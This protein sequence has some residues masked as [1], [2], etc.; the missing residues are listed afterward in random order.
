MTA[1]QE[2]NSSLY[3]WNKGTL[4]VFLNALCVCGGGCVHVCVV[5]F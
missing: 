5:N 3:F 4:E 2:I 1:M